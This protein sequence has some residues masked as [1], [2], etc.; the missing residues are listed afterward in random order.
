[1]NDEER[2]SHLIEMIGTEVDDRKEVQQLFSNLK[3]ALPKLEALLERS[4]DYWTYE[5]GIYRF[6]HQSLK[7]YRLQT[8]TEEIVDALRALLPDQ[9]LNDWFM[10]I[11]GEGTGHR[12]ETE[13]NRLWLEHTR[14]ILEA[15]WH[16]RY[17]LEMAV[18][19]GRE[20]EHPPQR[21][22]SGW[23]ALLYLHGLR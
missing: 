4:T 22:P 8:A 14:P 20:L 18:R 11:I 17:M 9:P 7:V 13:H 5:D 12:F 16:A 6:Y 3:D 21:L 2:H 10:Q 23:A 1:M 19:Y 15:Y